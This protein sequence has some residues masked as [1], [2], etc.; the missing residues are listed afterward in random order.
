MN[1]PSSAASTTR[2]ADRTEHPEHA[3]HV[4]HG[5]HHVGTLDDHSA[6]HTRRPGG[7]EAH[8][9]HAGHHSHAGHGGHV[10]I[11]RRRFW[12]SLLL[13][14]PMIVTS[15][16]VMEWFGYELVFPGIDWVGPVLG[17]VVFFWAGWPFLAGGITEA[18]ER[19][20][21]MMLL[22]S[23]AI[24][25]AYAPR[26]PTASTGSTRSSGGSSRP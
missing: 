13:T 4:E 24:T 21:G 20:P 7:D 23:M 15:H 16:M 3:A 19:R 2:R 18:K 1:R 14:V 8:G 11:F 5:G 26:W 25:V 12:W 17:S 9:G 6:H 22:I 10:D